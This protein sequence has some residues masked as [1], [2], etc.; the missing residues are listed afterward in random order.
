MCVYVTPICHSDS[1]LCTFYLVNAEKLLQEL[2]GHAVHKEDVCWRCLTPFCIPYQIK[3]GVNREQC[4]MFVQGLYDIK[5]EQK[6]CHAGP[7]NCLL[8]PTVLFGAH[9]WGWV[10]RQQWEWLTHSCQRPTASRTP[11]S[12]NTHTLL[13]LYKL[14]LSL[15]A[16]Q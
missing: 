1:R 15:E 6:M 3:P 4:S 7:V 8:S 14:L 5:C 13:F 2:L 9:C 10:P 11:P 12:P 16:W